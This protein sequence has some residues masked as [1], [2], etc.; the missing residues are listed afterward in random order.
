MLSCVMALSLCGCAGESNSQDKGET[1]VET[2][3]E[4]SSAAV[5]APSVQEGAE[6]QA[7]TETEAQQ[8]STLKVRIGEAEFALELADNETAREF[9]ESL[10]LTAEFSE[11]NGNEKYLYLDHSLTSNGTIVPSIEAGDVMLYGNSCIV[12][13][14]EAHANHAYSYTPIGKI[15]PADG[16][17]SAAGEGSVEVSISR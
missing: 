11:L 16:I 13:F 4:A 3:S 14:Y 12:I 9:A 8:T 2:S 1:Q 15:V 7:E 5:E 17:A 10:P 6:T